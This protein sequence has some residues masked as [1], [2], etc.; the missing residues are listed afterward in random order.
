MRASLVSTRSALPRRKVASSLATA[1]LAGLLALQVQSAPPVHAAETVPVTY[2]GHA[3]P[4]AGPAPTEDK[5]QSKLWFNDGAWWA[6]MRVPAGVTVHRLGADHA[7]TNTGTVV[8]ERLAS[9]ADAL[10]E[11]GKLYVASRTGSGA[12]RV[13]RLSYDDATD[14]YSVDFSQQVASGGSESITLARDSLGR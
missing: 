1:S 4:T 8:D 13:I 7:W 11:G 5:P 10:W 3:Y 2:Q 12:L 9:T 6:L 14:S